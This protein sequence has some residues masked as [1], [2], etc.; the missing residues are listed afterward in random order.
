MPSKTARCAVSGT[1]P[2]VTFAFT[3][4]WRSAVSSAANAARSGRRSCKKG[5]RC[6]LKHSRRPRQRPVGLLFVYEVMILPPQPQKRFLVPFRIKGSWHLF[7]HSRRPRQ[8]P[9]G[10]LFIYDVIVYRVNPK[11]V[12]GTFS[13]HAG[14]HQELKTEHR[15][16][17][18][19]QLLEVLS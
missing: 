9:V 10:L 15:N 4:K 19:F 1:C 3:L 8:R 18:G 5:T 17:Y 7:K 11:K 6:L 2:A 14:A 13:A 12:P 16:R